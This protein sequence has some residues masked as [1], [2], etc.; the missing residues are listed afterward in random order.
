MFYGVP[1]KYHG[2]KKREINKEIEISTDKISVNMKK[3][4]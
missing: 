1:S 4:K 3:I 2:H